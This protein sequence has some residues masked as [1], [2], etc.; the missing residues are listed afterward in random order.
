MVK[1]EYKR[2]AKDT[3]I[4]ETKAKKKKKKKVIQLQG[5]TLGITEVF[6]EVLYR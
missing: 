6:L 5:Q 1:N 4:K 3:K 2:I